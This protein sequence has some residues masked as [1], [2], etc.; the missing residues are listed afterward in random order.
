[1]QYRP[2]SR[3]IAAA[4]HQTVARLK[5][6]L[7]GSVIGV[8]A[9]IAV[10]GAWADG[11]E[12][13]IESHAYS[14]F[15][16][17]KYG[18]NEVLDYVNPDAPK[19][20]EIALWAQGTFDSFNNYSR[21][22]VAASLPGLPY[23]G[24][25]ASTADDPY[26]S[27]C[28]MC[29]TMEYPESRDWVIFNLRDDVTFSDGRPLTAEDVKFTHE[30]FME[31]GI[32][33]Y[34]NVVSTYV[35]SV[36]VLGPYE[37]K[38]NFNPEAPRRD[39]IGIA[40]GGSTIFSKSWFEETG[41][42]L[43]EPRVEPFLGTGPYV[44]GDVDIGRQIIYERSPNW[45]AK[46]LPINTGRIN[47]DSIRIEYFA[48]AAAALE[49]FKSGAYTFRIENSSKE[50]ATGYDF[51]AIDNG[52]AVQKEFADGT[53]GYAQA[54]VFNL[55]R[56][57]W[58]DLRVRQAIGLMFNFEWS[59]ET[60]FYGL[61]ERVNSF[62]E[63]SDLEAIGVPTPEEVAILQPL[64]DD[65]LLD[66][67]IL[68]SEPVMAPTSSAADRPLDRRN[69]RAASALLDEAGWV[70]GDDGV[71]M[72]DGQPLS[73]EILSFSPAFDRI[74]NPYI[75]NLTR[76][77]VDAKL[78]RVDR[79]QY[80]DR[81]RSGDFDMVGHGFSMTFEPSSGLRQW[82]GSE[83]ADD[84]SRNLMRLRSEA[85]D[86]LMKVVIEAKTLDELTPAVHALDRALRAEGFW[87]QQWFKDKHT[88]AYYDMFRH[89]ENMPPYALGQLD[90][91]WYDEEAG[92]ALRAAGAFQ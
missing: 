20:G 42:R 35:D 4:Q 85:I 64:V 77:G 58:Q 30:L 80:V 34:R 17:V 44:L 49:G 2:R 43:D 81:R 76:L 25:L 54:F 46:D 9:A 14:N 86:R 37:V 78:D 12:T 41:A 16:E 31:Q 29:T 36:E 71:R 92:E 79:S 33:E 70:A 61:Y 60:L 89:P 65:G 69:L 87:V 45:W 23:E 88:V 91:W 50:W 8:G 73:L 57:K 40:G 52:Q 59:N 32:A 84:S 90:F 3:A 15:G 51:P 26:G 72:K 13:I 82:Y 48:D 18:P 5:Y 53:I 24:I 56:A 11:H 19:G 67:S 1:M 68:T 28:Y 63:N 38:F 75:E 83:T 22:G 55:D 7:M 10:N 39:V 47:F 27:Y 74:I 66:E 62:W 21:K 6:W